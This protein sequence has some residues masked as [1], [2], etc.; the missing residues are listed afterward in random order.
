M[1][2]SRDAA[3]AAVGEKKREELFLGG[4]PEVGDAKG[5]GGLDVPVGAA[6]RRSRDI[7]E[8][9]PTTLY[10]PRFLPGTA[11][12]A[13]MSAMFCT[14]AARFTERCRDHATRPRHARIAAPKKPNAAPTQIKT[15]PSGSV[16]FCMYGAIF[17][18]GT[19]TLGIPTPASVGRF[20]G[21]LI[22]AG[23]GSWVVVA[24]ALVAAGADVVTCT[25]D[26]A[27]VFF[28]S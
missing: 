3:P 2:E 13:F 9:A 12:I 10:M 14:A 27:S 22:L 7:L 26:V 5:L 4:V 19:I 11:V 28:E 23:G 6:E 21:C 25:V 1:T 8:F 17:V 18:S 24:G 15:V 20:E 16:D